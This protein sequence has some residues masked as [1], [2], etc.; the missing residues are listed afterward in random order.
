MC[1]WFQ[2]DQADGIYV[3]QRRKVLF[4][5]AICFSSSSEE[6]L[7]SSEELGPPSQSHCSTGSEDSQ[8]TVIRP[9]GGFLQHLELSAG[10]QR[11][12]PGSGSDSASN[13]TSSPGTGFG[14]GS[15]SSSDSMVMGPVLPLVLRRALVLSLVLI[16]ALVLVMFLLAQ[17]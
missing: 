10:L 8:Q 4:L 3:L 17:L 2:L 9:Q 6:V 15:D 14:S 16:K 13:P 1:F 7:R 11:A 5:Q 12:G